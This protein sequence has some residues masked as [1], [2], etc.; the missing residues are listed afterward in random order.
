[1]GTYGATRENGEYKE[2][3]KG[4]GERWKMIIE[5]EILGRTNRL[6]CLKSIKRYDFGGCSVGIIDECDL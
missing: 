1:M 3:V 6:L 5:Q 4:K 2:N